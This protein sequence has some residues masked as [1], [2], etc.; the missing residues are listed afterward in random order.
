MN[1][2]NQNRIPVNFST[3]GYPKS[4]FCG[5]LKSEEVVYLSPSW[6]YTSIHFLWYTSWQFFQSWPY[7]KIY[8]GVNEFYNLQDFN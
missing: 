2:T 8:R 3:S 4:G 5:Y 6:W 1:V 7:I